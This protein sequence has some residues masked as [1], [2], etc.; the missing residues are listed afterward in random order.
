[1]DF[2]RRLLDRGVFMFPANL[3]RS[4][5]GFAHTDAHIART[6]QACEDTLKEM[7]C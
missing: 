3:K 7:F 5:V 4:H 1:V 2:R 6:L